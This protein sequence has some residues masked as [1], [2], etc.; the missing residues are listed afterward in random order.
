M[1]H[2]VV[3][4]NPSQYVSIWL[5]RERHAQRK[6]SSSVACGLVATRDLK[7]YSANH[8]WVAATRDNLYGVF[9][10]F[11]LNQFRTQHISFYL[12]HYE[13]AQLRYPVSLRDTV[14]IGVCTIDAYV[15]ATID[16]PI[17]T[18]YGRRSCRIQRFNS[19]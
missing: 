18:E 9:E 1:S 5:N 3:C 6:R 10:R 2:D 15:V 19:V 8:S 11:I 17:F 13:V 4:A 16:I 7:S 12:Y 14:H